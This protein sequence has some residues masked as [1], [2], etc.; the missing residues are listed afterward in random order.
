[1]EKQ[2]SNENFKQWTFRSIYYI[3]GLLVLALGITLNTKTNLG[4]SAII[5]VPYV[6]AQIGDFNF[7]NATFVAY[8]LMVF[9]QFIIKGKKRTYFDLLQIPL[10]IIFTRFLNVYNDILNFQGMSKVGQGVLLIIAVI[11]TGIG[12]A[13]T[14]NMK[15]IANPGDAIV[16]SIADR[17][18]KPMGFTKNI[19]DICCVV[20]SVSIGFL[21]SGTSL[22]VGVGTL[23]SMLGVGRVI[24]VFNRLFKE[25]MEIQSGLGNV[26]EK[27]EMAA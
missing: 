26:E 17:I 18:E 7:G 19:F 10:S 1:M 21:F 5:S 24:A 8:V 27:E 23:V 16:S 11:L 13:M 2:L 14:V 25:K 9:A 6:I 12:A 3:V 15:L 22:G 4:V 20:V